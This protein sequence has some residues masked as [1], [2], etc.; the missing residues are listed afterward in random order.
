MDAVDAQTKDLNEFRSPV[1]VL[2][3]FFQKSR[4]QWKQKYMDAKADLKRFKVRVADVSNSRDAWREK[5]EARQTEL[6]AMQAQLQ[7]LQNQ[8]NGLH[9]PTPLTEQK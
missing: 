6:Q 7:E 1:R 9:Q 8:I 3:A 5:A 4:D 2:A